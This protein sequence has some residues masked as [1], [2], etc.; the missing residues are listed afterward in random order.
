MIICMTARTIAENQKIKPKTRNSGIYL[1]HNLQPES[2]V[3]TNSLVITYAWRRTQH[4]PFKAKV[5]YVFDR[6]CTKN[7]PISHQS[8]SYTPNCY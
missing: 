5:P 3:S 6:V 8:I 1:Q 2:P 4:G 7:F